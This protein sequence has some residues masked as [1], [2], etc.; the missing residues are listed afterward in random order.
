[1]KH[2][3]PLKL[4][5][6]T[7]RRSPGDVIDLYNTLSPVMQ[8]AAGGDMLNF[9]YW[10]D[11]NDPISAQKRLCDLVAEVA[12]LGSASSLIDLGSGLGAP[13]RYWSSVHGSLD[14]V[15]VNINR[16]QMLQSL[17]SG[18][19]S[20]HPEHSCVN[21]TSVRLPFS[22]RCA[23]RIVALESAQHFRPFRDFVSGCRRI[24]VPGGHFVLA[25]PVTARPLGGIGKL[26]NLGILSFTWSSEHYSEE[27]VA[28]VLTSGGF[29][30]GNI[31]HIGHQVYEPLTSYYVE[32]RPS[33]RKRILQHYPSYVETVLHRSLL[34]MSQ[35]SHAG[36]IDY[37]VIKAT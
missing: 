10:K 36:L 20:S 25:M 8:L 33:I 4:F 16:N 3:N 11:A 17:I 31:L 15:C 30:I 23:E 37:L 21:A 28:E 7:F 26:V 24:L 29:R 34:K 32:N 18:K 12:D 2:L 27:H 22:D 5:L 14:I 9:G 35:A 6:W 19:T 1:L 13:A